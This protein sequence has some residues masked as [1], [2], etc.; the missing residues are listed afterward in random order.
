[1]EEDLRLRPASLQAF[2]SLPAEGGLRGASLWHVK[3][4]RLAARPFEAQQLD[5]DAWSRKNAEYMALAIQIRQMPANPRVLIDRE[6][7][8]SYLV[9]ENKEVREVL[10]LIFVGLWVWFMTH[11]S[12]AGFMSQ[13]ATVGL[14]RMLEERQDL[15]T[16]LRLAQQLPLDS[17]PML[18]PINRPLAVEVVEAAVACIPV[19]GNTVAVCEVISGRDLFGYR[20]DDFDRAVIAAAV[21]IPVAA[22]FVKGGR[23][24][25][26][27][28]RL[29]RMYGGDAARWS[30]SLAVGERLAADSRALRA[31]SEGEAVLKGGARI[32]ARLGAEIVSGLERL[33][34]AGASS[35]S[36]SLAPTLSQTLKRLLESKPV[37]ASLDELALKRVM[38]KGPGLN[39]MKGQLLEELLESRVA[40]WLRDPAGA[41]A[42]GLPSPPR[43]LE[44][45][46]GHM[47]RDTAGRQITDGTIGHRDGPVFRI[48]AIFEAKA[49]PAAARELRVSQGSISA[50]SAA[51]RAELR[52]VA[53]DEF[54]ERAAIARRAGRPFPPRPEQQMI[55]EI[56]REISQRESGGQVGRDIERLHPNE[57]GTPTRL[58]IGGEEVAVHASSKKTKFFGVLPKDVRAGT[59]E[60][61]LQGLGYQFE[62]LGMDITSADL[63]E[64]AQK[65]REVP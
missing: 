8:I 28:A 39:L 57:D 50:L 9:Q 15:V 56:E 7:G 38:D 52:A 23:A 3:T 64:L 27:A 10:A 45:V 55:E 62:A 20:L 40:P 44:F 37:L 34:L 46:P 2:E 6:R 16:A 60:R 63:I 24:L 17:Q 5:P 22:R 12:D 47:I 11:Y 13:P 33:S 14:T 21:L 19:L 4:A 35:P 59:I 53:R 54:R 29:T 26:S 41:G 49:G 25:Y 61:D 36:S 51:D 18:I 65:L 43:G 30:K 58:L 48:V 42:L 31:V 32:D 1:M